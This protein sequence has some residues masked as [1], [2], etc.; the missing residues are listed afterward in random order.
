M[1]AYVAALSARD[2]G[3]VAKVRDLSAATRAGLEKVF[4]GMQSQR[5]SIVGDPRITI[6]GARAKVEAT[7]RYDVEQTDGGRRQND[8]SATVILNRVRNQ[9]RIV[10]VGQ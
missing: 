7:L 8:V 2:V 5:V 1:D 6:D 4:G 9:W 10:R 3:E